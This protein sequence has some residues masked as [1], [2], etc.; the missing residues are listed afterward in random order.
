MEATNRHRKKRNIKK[1]GHTEPDNVRNKIR[2][3]GNLSMS[4]L[5][6]I[7]EKRR[8]EKGSRHR[9]GVAKLGLLI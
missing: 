2:K 5:S 1:C 6:L 7:K 8:E 3:T 9:K 4:K